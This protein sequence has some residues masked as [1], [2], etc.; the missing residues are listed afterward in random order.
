MEIRRKAIRSVYEENPG[1]DDQI[2]LFVR[3]LAEQIDHLQDAECA[4]AFDALSEKASL[5]GD[6]AEQLGYPDFARI[7][8]KM[9]LACR[10]D[11][12]N[13]VYESLV[14]LTELTRCIRL[15]H[16]GAA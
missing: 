8:Q 2:D 5:L 1:L 3:R 9:C 10:E 15:G 12:A 6:E 14:Q 13:S 7:V 11:E 4:G 16:R